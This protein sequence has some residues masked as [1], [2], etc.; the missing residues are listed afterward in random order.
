MRIE[1]K[2]NVV[3]SFSPNNRPVAELSPGE[4]LVVE[5]AGYG[6]VGV[7]G[8]SKEK[9]GLAAT[10]PATGPFFIAGAEP[11]DALEIEF[12]EIGVA[13]VGTVLAE[14]PEGPG[15][16]TYPVTGRNLSF[17]ED[18]SVPINPFVAVAGV[19]PE[20]GEAPTSLAGLHGGRLL[21]SEARPGNKLYLPVFHAGAMLALGDVRLL[22]GDGAGG[23][24]GISAAATIKFKVDV[25]K[26]VRRAGPRIVT[27]AGVFFYVTAATLPQAAAG[28]RAA[29]VNQL[30]NSGFSG[31]EAMVLADAVGQLGFCQAAA[32]PYTC[33]FFVPSLSVD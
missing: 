25:K 23:D 4:V 8:Q 33:K 19:L 17:R 31:D 26:A 28:A 21:A 12:L 6:P 27:G 29:G 10:A 18:L 7:T 11:G 9:I 14:N 20:K 5:T 15:E 22:K 2:D 24:S 16:K 13:L 3:Y 30:I 32:P 1:D